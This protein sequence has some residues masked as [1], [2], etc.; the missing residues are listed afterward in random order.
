M[1]QD[2]PL[3]SRVRTAITSNKNLLGLVASLILTVICLVLVFTVN[4]WIAKVFFAVITIGAALF[5]RL[6]F[7]GL[8][9]KQTYEKKKPLPE[10]PQSVVEDEFSD[11]IEG[12]D[13]QEEEEE[14]EEEEEA[15]EE[16][17]DME[18]PLPPDPEGQQVFISEKGNR[19]H[20]D[21]ACTGL[22]FADVVQ[23]IS[24]DEALALGRQACM[25][26]RHIET[27]A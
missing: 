17:R 19:Y 14:E 11:P 8:R 27:E 23:E 2:N 6:L 10:T 12:L 1:K 3:L 9:I 13:A 26:C 24:E 16:K 5:S 7:E 4:H 25:R 22:R 21:K 18:S 15:A 20:Q